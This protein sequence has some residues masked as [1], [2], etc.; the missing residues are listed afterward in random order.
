MSSLL[1][2]HFEKEICSHSSL[3]C[4]SSLS[5]FLES[6]LLFLVTLSSTSI[7]LLA[8]CKDLMHSTIISVNTST[9][10]N[11]MMKKSHSSLK[12]GFLR[13][14]WWRRARKIRRTT[15]T[16]FVR[17]VWGSSSS[18]P[19]II[20]Y[21]FVFASHSVSLTF[22]VCLLQDVSATSNPLNSADSDRIAIGIL[23]WRMREHMKWEK[24]QS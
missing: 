17:K 3:V 24:T 23:F 18:C 20:S 21:Y 12:W 9:E 2:F 13:R 4:W 11:A 8:N 22:C 19:P 6:C 10:K 7:F 14:R 1:L 5:F 16:K 15:G